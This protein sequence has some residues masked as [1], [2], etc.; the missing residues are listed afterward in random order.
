MSKVGVVVIGRNEG[1]RLRRC[2]A[3]L[4][5]SAAPAVYVDSGS[6]DGSVEWAAARCSAV[7]QLDRSAPFTAARAR[8]AGVERLLALSPDTVYVQFVDGDC[9]VAPG[10]IERGARELDA[11]PARAA[12]CGRRRER[13]RE[14]SVYNRLCDIEWDTPIG[15]AK[16]CG[17]D[18]MM[19]VAA[20]QEVGGFDAS[21]IAGEDDELCV[22]LRQRR[23]TILRVDAEMTLHDAAMTRF[24]QWWRRAVRAGHCF[25]QGFAMHGAAP[26]RLWRRKNASIVLW[27]LLVPGL[28]LGAG[29][30]TG[31]SSLLLLLAYPVALSRHYSANRRRGLSPQ[32]AWLYSAFCMLGNFPNLLGQAKYLVSRA[33]RRAPRLIEYKVE[34][35]S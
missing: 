7:V 33:R 21:V 5:P 9:E 8:N 11:D 32:D 17:G 16:A 2:L 34:V 12:V 20:F 25:A 6:D 14:R 1:E 13:H 29:P 15:P 3:S 26:E 27:A 4:Q 10:W 30:A 23:H 22:R 24:G 28:A 31:G 18:S 35:R 19:R